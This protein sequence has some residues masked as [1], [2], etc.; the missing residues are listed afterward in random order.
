MNILDAVH[1]SAAQPLPEP[2]PLPALVEPACLEIR[3]SHRRWSAALAPAVVDQAIAA[4]LALDA[5]LWPAE[6]PLEAVVVVPDPQMLMQLDL[7]AAPAL[8][9]WHG[10]LAASLVRHGGHGYRVLLTR[11]GAAASTFLLHAQQHGG[12]GCLTDGLLPPLRDE[13]TPAGRLALLAAAVGV[14]AKEN[15]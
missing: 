12:A 9:V 13:I 5:V 1:S 15:A 2:R 7:A 8:V 14:P 3:R 10:D 6:E 11:G 4:A